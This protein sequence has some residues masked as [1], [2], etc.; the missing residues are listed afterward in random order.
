[1]VLRRVS[2]VEEL[3]SHPVDLGTIDQKIILLFFY[4]W[5][6]Y[7]FYHSLNLL[8]SFHNDESG[9][10]YGDL[11]HAFQSPFWVIFQGIPDFEPRN[12]VN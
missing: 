4:L 1:M 8:L 3:G 6:S 11:M 7:K 9:K 2:S 12:N 5:N 10:V